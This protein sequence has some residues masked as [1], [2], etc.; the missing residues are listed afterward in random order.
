MAPLL[1]LING[2]WFRHTGLRALFSNWLLIS[3]AIFFFI[4]T[5]FLI[6]VETFRSSLGRISYSEQI[7]DVSEIMIGLVKMSSCSLTLSKDIGDSIEFLVSLVTLIIV[8]GRSP[9][10]MSSLFGL[11]WLRGIVLIIEWVNFFP[12]MA[13]LFCSYGPWFRILFF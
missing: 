3:K 4:G 2:G 8:W 13:F 7:L 5:L 12:S 9:S 11:A 10:P 6:W 1:R